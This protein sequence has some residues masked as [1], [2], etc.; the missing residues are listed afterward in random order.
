M[1]HLK[2]RHEFLLQK[3][4][5]VICTHPALVEK[6][7]VFNSN[8]HLV[9]N[10]V[11]WPLFQRSLACPQLP[12][13]LAD[14]PSPRVGYVGVINDKIDIPLLRRIVDTLP[15]VHLVLVGPNQLRHRADE[16]TLLEHPRVH[17][18]GFRP[19]Q[20]LPLYMKGLDVALMPYRINRWTA[21]IDPLKLYEYF[22]VGL[23]VVSTPIPAVRSVADLLYVADAAVFPRF[24]QEALTEEEPHRREQRRA[25][26][27][28]HTWEERVSLIIHLLQTLERDPGATR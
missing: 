24:V 11:D 20:R 17:R 13:D 7:R 8:V 6:A 4:D 19:P 27:R 16:W 1:A 9:P 15:D 22:A 26:A 14:I 28:R 10:A 23:P 12:E 25:F 3:A 5:L 21:H 2:E 18:L